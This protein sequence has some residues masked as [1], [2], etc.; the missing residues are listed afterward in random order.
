MLP[1]LYASDI[2]AACVWWHGAI[3]PGYIANNVVTISITKSRHS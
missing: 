3:P 1:G 2:R